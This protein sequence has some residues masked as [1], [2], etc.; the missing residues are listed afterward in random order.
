VSS[1]RNARRWQFIK[2][3]L[4]VGLLCV[5]CLA[6]TVLAL[7]LR[8]RLLVA[9]LGLSHVGPLETAL[10]PEQEPLTLTGEA[11][12]AVQMVLPPYVP[13]PLTLT[14]AALGGAV[15]GDASTP[16]TTAYLLTLDESSLNQLLWGRIFSDRAD[17]GR[18]CNLEVDLQPGGLVL[19]GDVDLGLRRQRMGLLL[20]QDDGAPTVSLAGVVL[21][22]ELYTLPE[23]ST[24]V[25][26]LLPAGRQVRRALR[27]LTLVGPLPG[28]AH[29]DIVRFHRDRLQILA[30]AT[31]PAPAPADTGWQSL[32]P[33]VELREIDVAVDPE[34]S[35]ERL[36][37][38]RLDPSQVQFRV[39]YNPSDPRMISVWGAEAQCMLVV[40]G[41]YFAP[42]DEGGET[43]GLLV[44]DGQ[45][46]GTPLDNYA[47]MFA[48][49]PSGDV[50]VRWLQQ[51]PYDPQ[52]PLAQAV[53]SFPV[54]VKPGGVMGF[55][56]EADDGTPA[57]RTVV[58]QDRAGSVLFIV[59]P[60]GYLSLHELA[61]FLAE[62]D[63]AIDVALNLDGGGSTGMWLAAGQARVEIESFT[64][65]PSVI[66]VQRR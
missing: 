11:Q 38:V 8:P 34:Q 14:P 48:V 7:N 9:A 30:Q 21:N 3:L 43:I 15:V 57:R 2:W 16:G 51:S 42:Q 49:T 56:A 33:G 64:P 66:A 46:W 54:L 12:D 58:A 45:R 52:E 44:S 32:E 37:I 23:D 61:V 35:T 1:R 53:Q 65:V 20:L 29:P 28:E 18:Y 19:Y 41:A 40:N 47:G 50:S 27:V 26:H 25:R 5:A 22:Q 62:S 10:P 6:M 36:R 39:R 13:D 31:Y 55:P 63:L 60:G 24:L 17:G 59:A 4:A